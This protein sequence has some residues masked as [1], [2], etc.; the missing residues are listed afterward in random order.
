MVQLT[1]WDII[2]SSNSPSFVQFFLSKSCLVWFTSDKTGTAGAGGVARWS[3]KTRS[4]YSF[5]LIPVIVSFYSS[6]IVDMPTLAQILYKLALF[7]G[8]ILLMVPDLVGKFNAIFPTDETKC[9]LERMKL[10]VLASAPGNFCLF[11]WI[12]R[13]EKL[14]YN[15]TCG[16]Q[17]AQQWLFW[18]K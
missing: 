6:N 17:L 16:T 12:Q 18:K 5:F 9:L 2:I 8:P 11:V 13:W 7:A 4:C 10:W 1:S 14:S 3:L 15:V